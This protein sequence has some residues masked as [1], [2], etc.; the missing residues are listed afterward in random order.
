MGSRWERAGLWGLAGQEEG[1]GF[2]LAS[3]VEGLPRG[4]CLTNLPP[5]PALL[6][7]QGS[8]LMTPGGCKGWGCS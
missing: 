7:A 4:L 1:K 6:P 5:P 2:P 8:L 3:G